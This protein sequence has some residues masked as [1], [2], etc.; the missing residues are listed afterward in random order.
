MI[1][2]VESD[3]E[4]F[5]DN[6][7]EYIRK[8][9]EK[10]GQSLFCERILEEEHLIDSSDSATRRRAAYDFLQALCIFF[11]SQVVAIYSQYI[12]AMQQVNDYFL[13]IIK[14]K[15]SRSVIVFQEYLQNPEK[16]WL[17]KDTCIF[18]V[19]A[20]AS[21]GET[22]KVSL[23]LPSSICRQMLCFSSVWYYQNEFIH[24]HSIVLCREYLT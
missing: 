4:E 12:E 16:N 21:K 22:Q 23:H 9:I 5:E 18:L 14:L 19:L 2:I 24:Q 20:L 17:K 13:L 8:D 11:E 10:S 7:E 1:F 3:V 15:S 6:P